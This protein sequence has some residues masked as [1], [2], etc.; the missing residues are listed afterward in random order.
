G[1]LVWALEVP[2]GASSPGKRICN[3]VG[4]PGLTVKAE[5]VLAVI[6]ACVTSLAV[7]VA[8]PAV[9][10]VALKLWLPALSAVLAGRVAL[11]SVEVRW[12]VSL[13]LTKFQ[14]ASTD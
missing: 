4:A 2:G 1:G 10:R 8:V 13:V 3:L 6:P 5:R 14:L 7:P 12:T 9:F 11:V